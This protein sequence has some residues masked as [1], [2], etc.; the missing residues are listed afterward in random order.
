MSQVLLFTPPFFRGTISDTPSGTAYH[1]KPG[2]TVTANETDQAFL[3]GLGFSP[4]APN[5]AGVTAVKD[6]GTTI[7]NATTID[8]TSGATV[9]DLGGGVAGVSISGGGGG[10]YTYGNGI[11]FSGTSPTTIGNTGTIVQPAATG[12]NS[13]LGILLAPGAPGAAGSAAGSVYIT[14]PN[15]IGTGTYPPGLSGSAF[16]I[17]T[18]DVAITNTLGTGQAGPAIVS[19]GGA[20]SGIAFVVGAGG[21]NVGG[22]ILGGTAAIGGLG[23]FAAGA[24]FYALILNQGGDFTLSGGVA[25]GGETANGGSVILNPGTGM[26]ASTLNTNGGIQMNYVPIGDPS[27]L[28]RVFVSD[29]ITNSLALSAG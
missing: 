23:V 12:T 15:I 9:S 22:E 28:N 17:Y 11:Y 4:A 14:G 16:T 2:E 8:F 29:T 18:G 26:G 3:L 5:A 1:V 24:A 6:S 27:I 10:S 13:G 21:Q 7:T 25:H 20:S 19:A